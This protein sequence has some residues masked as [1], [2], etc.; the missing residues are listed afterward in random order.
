MP[1]APD[2]VR[3]GPGWLYVAPVGSAEPADLT[4]PWAAAW[5]P[6]GYTS[7][8]HSYTYTPSFEPVD[9]AEELI[10]IR[11][12]AT[13]AESQLA[14]SL[15]EMTS[16]NLQRVFNGGTITTG[17]GIVTFEPP[18]I[19]DVTRIAIGWEAVDAKERWIFRK[20]LQTGAVEIARQKA[21]NKSL[22]PGQFNC[23][24][25]GAGIKP[26]VAILDEAA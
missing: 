9:V 1:G 20:C 11:Y 3:V 25:P 6:V 19:G 17:T 24:L 8:G 2:K 23:E 13:G 15:A 4:T 12:E 10:P 26:F 5:I 16:K 7:E 22:L 18:D 21:P 14:F